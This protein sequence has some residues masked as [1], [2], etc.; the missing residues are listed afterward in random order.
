MRITDKTRKFLWAKF[1]NRCAICKAEIITSTVTSEEFNIGEECHIISSKPT[2]PR[3]IPNLNEYDNYENLLLLC[4]NHH[5]EI[6][7]LTDTYTEE[8]L[9][10]IKTNHENW[11]KNTI[12]EAID[13][14]AK[15]ETPK[16]L[17]RITSGKDLYNIINEAHGYKTDYDEVKDEEEAN[18]S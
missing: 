2:G 4:K 9:R 5:K 16:F 17:A 3:H 15:N 14:K 6:D 1:G 13:K 12:K 18:F 7:E 8:L 10:Y 11:V